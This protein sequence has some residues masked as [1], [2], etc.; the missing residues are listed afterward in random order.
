M[1]NKDPIYISYDFFLFE[2]GSLAVV[3]EGFIHM[4]AP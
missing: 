3:L 4:I 2:G 1:T